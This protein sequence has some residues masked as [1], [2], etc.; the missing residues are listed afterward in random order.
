MLYHLKFRKYLTLKEKRRWV[1][2]FSGIGQTRKQ[3]QVVEYTLHNSY[4]GS[5]M[6]F[7]VWF[8]IIQNETILVPVT[9][10][11]KGY[12]RVVLS[13]HRPI[14]FLTGKQTILYQR[15][16]IF[17]IRIRAQNA[18]ILSDRSSK[19]PDFELFEVVPQGVNNFDIKKKSHHRGGQGRGVNTIQQ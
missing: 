7:I 4:N 19:N 9:K 8:L 13:C 2:T 6:M 5:L 15:F 12:C 16:L 3:Q 1:C 17:W 10:Q 11:K 14:N 18:S